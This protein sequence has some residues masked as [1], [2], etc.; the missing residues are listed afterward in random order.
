MNAEQTPPTDDKSTDASGQPVPQ[1]V[2][3][4]RQD[5][6]ITAR[7]RVRRSPRYGRFIGVGFICGMLIGLLLDFYAPIWTG[8]ASGGAVQYSD[9][10][11]TM[12]VVAVIG[13]VGAFLGCVLAL[14]LDRKG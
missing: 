4:S 9:T 14:A 12:F 10:S 11:M 2:T 13:L 8:G 7:M 5:P 3:A 6:M 1:P